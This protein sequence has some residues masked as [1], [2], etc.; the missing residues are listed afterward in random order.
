MEKPQETITII[1]NKKIIKKGN[2][3]KIVHI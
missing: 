1:G 3:T 2:Y